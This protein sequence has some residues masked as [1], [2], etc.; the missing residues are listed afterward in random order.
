M[1]YFD[2]GDV[3][4]NRVLGGLGYLIFF[5]PFITCPDSRFGKYCANQGLIAVIGYLVISVAFWLL[6]LVLGW[7][8]F[9]GFIVWLVGRLCYL[10]LV[11][12]QF[13]YMFLAV[14][15]GDARPLPY[16]GN[17]TIIK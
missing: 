1:A 17:Y 13:Y 12:A 5:L 2:Q 8:P 16:I 11:V 3:E 10:A 7:I 15:K 14:T 6:G 9:I 4:K